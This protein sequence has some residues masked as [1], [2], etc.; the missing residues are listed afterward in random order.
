MKKILVT[1]GMLT[2]MILFNAG[3]TQAAL[4]PDIT[5][6]EL[7]RTSSS[8]RMSH[9]KHFEAKI[10]RLATKLNLDPD[11][12]ALDIKS[13]KSTKDILKKHGITKNQL[14]EVMGKKRSR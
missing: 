14:R 1:G 5:T 10:A 7:D 8:E 3:I 2:Y 4:L 9:E 11:Q 12:L 6:N 13:G